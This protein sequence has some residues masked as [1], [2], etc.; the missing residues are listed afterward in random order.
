MQRRQ[1]RAPKDRLKPIGV[2]LLRSKRWL[3]HWQQG[4]ATY[5]VTFRAASVELTAELRAIVLSAARHFDGQRYT[6][7]AAVVMPDHVHLLLTPRESEPGQ[8]WSL[9]SILHSVKGYAAKEVNRRLGRAGAVW[10]QESFDRMTRDEEEFREKWAYI[11]N[12]PVTKALCE[13]ADDWDALYER[14]PEYPP[15]GTG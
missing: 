4:G 12:N 8:C 5:F 14:V 9:A 1:T 6:L 10:M 15:G 13:R 2:Q 11:R 3:P 7:W